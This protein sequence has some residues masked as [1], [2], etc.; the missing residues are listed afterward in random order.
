MSVETSSTNQPGDGDS[1]E[2]GRHR[3]T[4]RSADSAA[5]PV[6]LDDDSLHDDSLDDDVVSADADDDDLDDDN[7]VRGTVVDEDADDEADSDPVVFD[8]DPVVTDSDAV[9]SDP[10]AVVTDPDEPQPTFT[11]VDD[12]P[13]DGVPDP[14]APTLSETD[15]VPVVPAQAAPMSE[16]PVSEVPVAGT[17]TAPVSPVPT[18]GADEPLLGDPVGL[19]ASWQ[20]AQA[21][22]VDDPRAAVADAAELVEHTAQTLIGSL[23]QRQRQLRDQWDNNGSATP[24]GAGEP[25]DTEQLRH[26]M[27][28]YRSL[29]NQLCQP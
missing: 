18:I 20:Q 25:S 12:G 6:D 3:F 24:G 15:D 19:R 10:D 8:R 22:F 9:V 7:V 4:F 27:Q 16:A 29:F 23:Q 21:G 13:A 14:T 2:R 28:D 5:D 26:L 1:D 17:S 11:P